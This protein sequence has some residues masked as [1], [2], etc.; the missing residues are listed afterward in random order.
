M[1]QSSK[2]SQS[3]AKNPSILKVLNATPVALSV[4]DIHLEYTY[5]NSKF[6][7]LFGME[8]PIKNDF[9]L[10]IPEIAFQLNQEDANMLTSEIEAEIETP[11]I[12]KNGIRKLLAISRSVYE[13]DGEKFVISTIRDITHTIQDKHFE[14]FQKVLTDND[15]YEKLL[16]RFS[17]FIFGSND[18]REI[19]EGVGKLA[20][21]LLNLEDISIL[22]YNAEEET[23]DRRV[24]MLS[25]KT[26]FF[27]EF[28][29]DRISIP[30]DKGISGRAA[31]LRT[32]VIVNDVALDTDFVFDK[33]N[34][35][36]EMAVP[37]VYKNQL[38]G[39][40]DLQ[41]SRPNYFSSKIKNTIQGIAS[42]LAIKLTELANYKRLKDKHGE[43]QALIQG[44]PFP[45]ALLDRNLNYLE[46]SKS[47]EE[48][49]SRGK[50]SLIGKNHY[51]ENPNI[52]YRWK[53]QISRAL[54][55]EV[56]EMKQEY[57][58]RKNGDSDWF[59]ARISPWYTPENTIG[60]IILVAEVISKRV[61]HE[62][63]LIRTNEEL[64][65][66]RKLGKLFTWSFDPEAGEF[67]WHSGILSTS[68]GATGPLGLDD[69][70]DL[71][72]PDYHEDFTKGLN[73]AIANRTSFEL[74][75]PIRIN[76]QRH[77]IHNRAK[78]IT[79]RDHIVN[80]L[81]TAQDITDQIDAQSAYKSKN[82]ELMKINQELD[83][84]VYKTA[85]DLRAPLANL[86]GLIGVMRSETDRDLL[87][88]YFDLQEQSINRLDDF[89]QKI[90]TYTKNA[91]L[92]LQTEKIDFHRMIDDIL[93][94]FMFYD[95]S[96][97]V[98]KMVNI[99]D[100]VAYY[101]DKERIETIVKNLVSNAIKFSDPN[102]TD[103]YL[104]I[105]VRPNKSMIEILV[106]DN[107]LGISKQFEDRIFDMF[108]RGHKSADG[109]G[110][111][112]YIVKETVDKLRG[113]IKM[114]SKEG[115]FTEFK[116]LLPNLTPTL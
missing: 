46:V 55:G 50:G 32:T 16:N 26:F 79:D 29:D 93:S 52:P 83:Q 109:A 41:S 62:V 61:E 114:S 44:H 80:I 47:W 49:F 10:F 65:E 18:Q 64:A 42:L 78:V 56:I 40:I 103:S 22:E 116:L 63:K 25:D 35:I 90:T 104:E 107:G 3:K 30:I 84:F 39:V 43:L 7:E 72:D 71:I 85:H 95:K 53:R 15:I 27:N 59:Y 36:S 37:I 60:G 96:D 57:Y 4:K 34:T 6:E 73:E 66:A 113:D 54:K 69:V 67:Q 17:T 58:Q 105:D 91:R 102:K 98:V 68:A 23:L 77:W 5:Y 21:D 76:G 12:T 1:K 94:S 45:V 81:G 97:Q 11:V 75:H 106:K 111:G 112:L 20:V 74:I 100:G 115:E 31:R 70:F 87:D 33:I 110:I 89:I 24:S 82:E 88:S 101:S 38:L 92:P 14:A 13:E 99:D 2:T 48:Q 9:D 19:L 8:D 28:G 108:Y 86:V 51:E